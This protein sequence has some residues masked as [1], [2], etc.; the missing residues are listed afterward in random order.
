V[1]EWRLTLCLVFVLIISK[2]KHIKVCLFVGLSVNKRI[3]LRNIRKWISTIW[4][5]YFNPAFKWV[6]FDFP[7]ARSSREKM[8]NFYAYVE[9]VRNK[10][11]KK[12]LDGSRVSLKCEMRCEARLRTLIIPSLA[13]KRTRN[14]KVDI[15]IFITKIPL[16]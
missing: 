1:W 5:R 8:T 6:I 9:K 4:S 16:L 3:V 10:K 13:K 12:K 14:R 11:K 15:P 2:L 7:F